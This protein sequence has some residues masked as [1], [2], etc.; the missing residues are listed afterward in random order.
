[1][2]QSTFSI[3]GE[4][5]LDTQHDSEYIAGLEKEL[6]DRGIV[7]IRRW[8]LEYIAASSLWWNILWWDWCNLDEKDI[9]IGWVQNLVCFFIPAL[10][11]GYILNVIVGVSIFIGLHL[12]TTKIGFGLRQGSKL[13]K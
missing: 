12:L 10:V 6:E 2:K 11:F 1:M 7:G 3:I 8:V 4:R 5:Y 9:K 13:N